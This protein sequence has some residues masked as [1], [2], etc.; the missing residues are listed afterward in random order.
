[1]TKKQDQHEVRLYL[2]CKDTPAYAAEPVVF[3]L[4]NKDQQLDQGTTHETGATLFRCTAMVRRTPDG[5]L[6]WS[7]PY[8]HGTAREPF[9]YLGLA[10]VAAPTTWIRRWKIML[11]A[12]TAEDVSAVVGDDAA[13]L[14]ATIEVL[15]GT[16]P[17]LCGGGWTVSYGEQA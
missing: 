2:L 9:L 6:R 1:M 7:G 10:A 17:P 11:Q 5:A 3:G 16:R 12:I 4:Q 8:V 13:L 15:S 14:E